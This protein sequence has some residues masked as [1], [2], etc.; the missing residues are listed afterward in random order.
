MQDNNLKSR[1]IMRK[2]L[3]LPE[4]RRAELL[5]GVI[6][7][8]APTSIAHV[9]VCGNILL[10]LL[11]YLFGK[12]CEV[13]S[14]IGIQFRM[15]EPLPTLLIPDITVVCDRKKIKPQGIVGVPEFIIEVLSPSNAGYDTIIK[16]DRYMREGVKEYWI[17]DPAEKKVY[18]FHKDK[19]P[20]FAAVYDRQDKI[21]VTVL[22]GF[23]IDMST[24]FTEDIIEE[25]IEGE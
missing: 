3:E 15:D 10:Q 7:D 18:V 11:N 2:Y 22:D 8:M 6:V 9:R 21:T 20:H 24:V 5:D 17:A 14:H 12:R 25:D 1:D 19:N 13:F 23:E 4:E 16:L